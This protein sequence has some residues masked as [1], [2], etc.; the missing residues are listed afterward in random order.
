MSDT[1][2]WG[3]PTWAPV[4]TSHTIEPLDPREAHPKNVEWAAL[5]S[6]TTHDDQTAMERRYRRP[7]RKNSRHRLTRNPK[8]PTRPYSPSPF[9]RYRR[10]ILVATRHRH[11]GFDYRNGVDGCSNLGVTD[12]PHE[13]GVLEN[14]LQR[15]RNLAFPLLPLAIEPWSFL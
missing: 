5:S 6:G 13:E 14:R 8:N 2:S 1:D 10:V 9:P 12:S 15:R 3:T 7:S 11:R 4:M